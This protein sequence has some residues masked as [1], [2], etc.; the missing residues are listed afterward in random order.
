[1]SA[2]TA[3]TEL[4]AA[5]LAHEPAC[6][7]DIRFVDDGRSD[8]ANRDLQPVCSSCPIFEQCAA[9][10]V[11]APRH[12]IVGYWAGRRR[13]VRPRRAERSVASVGLDPADGG[14]SEA[15]TGSDPIVVTPPLAEALSRL[16]RIECQKRWFGESV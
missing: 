16:D 5:L 11:A 1:M 7:D 13:G 8:A 3:W 14:G 9:Y 2:A 4:N 10:A 6:R 12:A 15:S